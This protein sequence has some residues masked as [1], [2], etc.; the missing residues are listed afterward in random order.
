MAGDIRSFCL[1]QASLPMVPARPAE[2]AGAIIIKRLAD[3]RKDKDRIYAVIQG[4]SGSSGGPVT[5]DH[6][7]PEFSYMTPLK[8]C[9]ADA[10]ITF[11]DLSFFNTHAGGHGPLGAVEA[12][13]LTHLKHPDDKTACVLGWTADLA[14]DTRGISGLVSIIHSALCLYHATIP[15]FQ[16]GPGL[17]GMKKQNFVIPD[18][19][20][21]WPE[22]SPL[23]RHAMAGAMTRDGGTAFCL[24]GQPPDPAP[25]STQPDAGLQS[26]HA[27]PNPHTLS[28][29]TTRPPIPED[30]LNRLNPAPA[31]APPSAPVTGLSSPFYMDP[32]ALVEVSDITARAHEKFLAFSQ[33]N[34]DHM[35]TQFAALTRGRC[36]PDPGARV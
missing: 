5:R 16:A 35:Q 22:T 8:Q 1:N 33:T 12:H 17:E 23:S 6:K 31:P 30:L 2:G 13:A 14:G 9:L 27:G 32:D 7:E 3:A 28:V 15:G 34:M 29:P 26:S 19:P 4:V 11:S 24:L 21:P 25:L 10:G 18:A 36:R 20:V